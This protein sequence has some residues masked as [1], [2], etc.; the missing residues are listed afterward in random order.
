[1]EN[2]IFPNM[3]INY[4]MFHLDLCCLPKHLFTGIQNKN[5]LNIFRSF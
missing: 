1:M 2:S 4:T 3:L 5:G